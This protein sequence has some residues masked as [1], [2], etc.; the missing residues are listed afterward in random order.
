MGEQL[1]AILAVLLSLCL[2]CQG[3]A[4]YDQAR[5]V[6]TVQE[7][8]IRL[9]YDP[10]P[11]D[12]AWGGK[13]R[14]ALNALREAEGLPPADALT[15]S[16]LALVH[17]LSPGETTLPKP[18][19]FFTDIAA[20]REFLA[21]RESTMMRRAQCPT[22]V[23]LGVSLSKVEPIPRLERLSLA[24][25]WITSAEDW[26]SP[27]QEGLMGTVNSCMSGVVTGNDERC[28]TVIQF[29]LRW[30]ESDSLRPA[31]S[32]QNRA[33]EDHAWVANILLRNII[34]AYGMVR[35][36]HEVT[37]EQE[38][39]VLD[40]FKRRVD[41]HFYAERDEPA[42]NHALAHTMPALALGVLVGDRTLM[43]P[44]FEYWRL[45]LD[46]MRD[47][48]SLPL[49]TRRGARW[50]HY[51]HMHIAQLIAVAELAAPQGIDLY[52]TSP[53]PDKTIQHAIGWLFDG[54]ADFDLAAPYARQNVGSP[55]DYRVPYF[56]QF[57]FGWLP[58]YQARFGNDETMMRIRSATIDARVCSPEA[59]EDD[60]T[61]PS[62]CRTF[63]G[64]PLS[65]AEIWTAMS[66]SPTHHMGYAAGCVQGLGVSPFVD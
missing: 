30:A 60:V 19:F 18:G 55:G 56:Q 28:R 59:L 10:G 61:D 57:H 16:S 33:F 7:A 49:E 11:A 14:T 6:L 45:V 36:V 21:R 17:R 32:R 20:R 48:G 54:L 64:E 65:L 51:T 39:I 37:P 2:L 58:A 27:I 22:Q 47:D 8:L 23:G 66:A 62:A 29:V 43:E 5:V 42:G 34:I 53:G 15:G 35:Q 26:F 63:K 44:S 31:V 13:T 9:G 3:A 1:R 38:T 50:A 12:G 4:A 46:S 52:A 40:W 24:Q 41:D 25:S